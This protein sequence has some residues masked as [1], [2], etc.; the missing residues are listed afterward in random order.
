MNPTEAQSPLDQEK[1]RQRR[2]EAARLQQI[3]IKQQAIKIAQQRE[4]AARQKEPAASTR[5]AALAKSEIA[6]PAPALAPQPQPTQPK[7]VEAKATLASPSVPSTK[8][9]QDEMRA[10][11]Q[12]FTAESK[13]EEEPEPTPVVEFESPP[14]VTAP[15]KSVTAPLKLLI[16][17]DVSCPKCHANIPKSQRG[18]LY[19]ECRRCGEIIKSAAT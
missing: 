13:L 3:Q 15:P 10:E 1:A 2:E 14:A 6:R 12:A 7:P 19:T 11:M 8:L 4:L 17:P 9:D 18:A 5:P 16:E